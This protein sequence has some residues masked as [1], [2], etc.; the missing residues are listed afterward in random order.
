MNPRDR[1]L[2]QEPGPSTEALQRL[3]RAQLGSTNAEV[4][5]AT[6]NLMEDLA[7]AREGA[8]RERGER[9]RSEKAFREGEER[10]RLALEAA[11]MGTFVWH[12]EKDDGLLDA[13]MLD[14]LGLPED[15]RI[16]LRS[17]LSSVIHPDD[18]ARYA[19]A[20]HRAMDPAGDGGLREDIRVRLPNGGLRWLSITGRAYFE[21]EPR[22]VARLAGVAMDIT[23][24]KEADELVRDSEEK[25]R[26]LVDS[27]DE[28]F[29]TIEVLFDADHR[30]IDYV[31]LQ[32]NPSFERLTGIAHAVGQRIRDIAP[33]HEDHWFQIYGGVAELGTPVRFEN[34]ARE[35]GRWYDVYAF[36][37]GAPAQH[38]VGVLFNDVTERKR[39]EQILRANEDRHSFLLQLSDRLQ[40]SSDPAR[41]KAE[42]ARAL[43]WK[44]QLAEVGCA[45]VEPDGETIRIEGECSDGRFPAK[46]GACRLSD[47][48]PAFGPALRA[49]EEIFWEDVAAASGEQSNEAATAHLAPMRAVAALPLRKEG[50]LVAFLYALHPEPR[51]WSEAER[52]LLQAVAERTWIAVEQGRAEEALRVSEERLRLIIENARDYAIFSLDLTRHVTSWNPGAE[53]LLGF[54]EEEILG[55]PADI[56]FTS[57][58]RFEGIPASETGQALTVGHAS[59]E[60]WH[61]RKDGSRFWGSGVMM[62]MRNPNGAA[63]G[64]VKILR[65]Q[66]RQREAQ[67]ALE[68]SQMELWNA[69]M[70]NEQARAAAETAHKAKDH[71]LAV[72]SHELRTPLTPVLMGLQIL[73]RQSDL[74]PVVQEIAQMIERNIRIEAGFIDDLLDMTRIERGK[75]ELQMH[76]LDLHDVL[77][78]ALEICRSDFENKQQEVSVTLEATISKVRG[79][80]VRLQQVFWNLLK[81]ASKFTPEGGRIEVVSHN[82]GAH[83]VVAVKDCGLGFAPEVASRL[84][85]AF[86]QADTSV[87][88]QFGGLG[89]GLAIAKATMDGHGGTISAHS[90]GKGHGATFTVEM[91]LS[92][93]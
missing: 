22:R 86:S 47:L 8:E 46:K 33:G 78:R 64:F 89:L 16:S 4:R 18:D 82:D 27:I 72:L 65:D 81:N 57:Q 35:M 6:L 15:S 68:R 52:R 43:A 71:F 38:R 9:E 42:A 88:Q 29:C 21:G 93:E 30:P 67:Q 55:Q 1:E 77:R 48:G 56:I 54:E 75:L 11:A 73:T 85:E 60:R 70:E 26:T 59:D 39:T 25:Y 79:D 90:D 87:T 34:Y 12:V 62:A 76:D 37:V 53:R 23:A 45:E 10:W 31:F 40:T 91:Q 66:T 92:E 69:A 17:A 74:P 7:M 44:L 28:G 84:F 5:R 3:L 24:R 19:E 13:R 32:V 14:L 63:V 36:R 51:P 20:L 58:D 61:Q 83:I 50:R 80:A 2:P 41:M 49:G